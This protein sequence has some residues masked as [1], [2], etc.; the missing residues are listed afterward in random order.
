MK[1]GQNIDFLLEVNQLLAEDNFQRVSESLESLPLLDIE[2]KVFV[3]LK[4]AK[5]ELIFIKFN[6]FLNVKKHEF[7]LGGKLCHI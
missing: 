4:T 3:E 7:E 2:L 5:K 6:Y 1:F